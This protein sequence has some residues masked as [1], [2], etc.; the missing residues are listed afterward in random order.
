M[1]QVVVMMGR[2]VDDPELRQTPNGI[3]VTV[4][5][6]A[7]DRPYKKDGKSVADF[8]DV[9][10]WRATAEFVCKYFKKGKPIL[11]Q[12]RF[13]N[14]SYLNKK[15]EKR[16]RTELIAEEVRFAGDSSGKEKPPLPEAPPEHSEPK[17]AS[18]PVSGSDNFEE[19]P[20]D[21]DLPF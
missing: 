5:R 2:L 17:A 4:F 18:K 9:V 6:I 19:I 12:G 1:Y 8:F 10:A 7:V 21:D 13:E 15:D 14:R 11:V 3:S 20:S 16:Y